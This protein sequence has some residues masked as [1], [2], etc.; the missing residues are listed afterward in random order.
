MD[1][2]HPNS[3]FS[4]THLSLP[5]GKLDLIKDI[6][7]Q[8]THTH[9]HTQDSVAKDP[10]SISQTS[11]PVESERLIPEAGHTAHGCS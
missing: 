5:L 7:R 1:D 6:F 3:T 8:H 10:S 4:C 2:P 11:T 9:T